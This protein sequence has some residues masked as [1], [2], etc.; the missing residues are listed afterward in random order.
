MRPLGSVAAAIAD[1]DR[2]KTMLQGI[3]DGRANA[4]P[5]HAAGHHLG[6]DTTALKIV[7]QVGSKKRARVCLGDHVFPV[8]GLNS[9]VYRA[10]RRAFS[11]EAERGNFL[12]EAP[13]IAQILGIFDGRAHDR[14]ACLAK[15]GLQVRRDLKLA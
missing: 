12:H 7:V 3:N 4:A 8:P 6:I 9:R 1:H 2:L 13:A 15:G 5:C 11:Q 10:V 14:Q